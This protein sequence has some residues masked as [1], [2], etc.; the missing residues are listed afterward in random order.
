MG[1]FRRA[2]AERRV[3]VDKFSFWTIRPHGAELFD[4][5]RHTRESASL[6]L[7]ANIY[8]PDQSRLTIRVSREDLSGQRPVSAAA[9][10]ARREK[11]GGSRL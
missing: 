6:R 3:A 5:I 7:I 10:G 4:A 9:R 1:G 2:F 11:Q 8:G